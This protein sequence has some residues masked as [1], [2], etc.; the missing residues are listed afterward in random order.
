[1][2]CVPQAFP[3][4]NTQHPRLHEK[5][6]S[7]DVASSADWKLYPICVFSCFV[8]ARVLQVSEV[9]FW[10]V[11]RECALVVSCSPAVRFSFSL[12]RLPHVAT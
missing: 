9:S 6:S 4:F 7:M 1:M 3:S 11:L 10:T 8:R 2:V 5:N 12:V